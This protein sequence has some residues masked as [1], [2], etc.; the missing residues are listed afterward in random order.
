MAA[1]AETSVAIVRIPE[2]VK[3]VK[4]MIYKN[5]RLRV[6]IFVLEENRFATG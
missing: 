3:R 4:F 5:Y 1:V 6:S 2:I